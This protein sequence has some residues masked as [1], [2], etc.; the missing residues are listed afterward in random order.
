MLIGIYMIGISKRNTTTIQ[1]GETIECYR[2]VNNINIY[3]RQS[4]SDELD[5]IIKQRIIK[6]TAILQYTGHNI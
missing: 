1:F 3:T 5:I 6:S 2:E 4:R